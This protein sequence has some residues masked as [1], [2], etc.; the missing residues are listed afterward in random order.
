MST[1]PGHNISYKIASTPGE[2]TD[3]PTNRRALSDQFSQGTLWVVKD[4]K[5]LQADSED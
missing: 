4:P 3:Q 5:S 1:D 2:G